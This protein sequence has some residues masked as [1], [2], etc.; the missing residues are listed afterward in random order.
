MHD[1]VLV[2]EAKERDR[3]YYKSKWDFFRNL[4]SRAQ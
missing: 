4:F 2:P 1:L 3:K